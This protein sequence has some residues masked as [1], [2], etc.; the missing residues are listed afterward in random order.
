M[1]QRNEDM[2]IIRIVVEGGV[3]LGN[4]SRI[5]EQYTVQAGGVKGKLKK[6]KYSTYVFMLDS[7]AIYT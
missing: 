7:S 3:T 2:Q 6:L 1:I 4:M 5:S